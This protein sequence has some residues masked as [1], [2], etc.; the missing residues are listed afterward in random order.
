MTNQALIEA[1]YEHRDLVEEINAHNV[2]VTIARRRGEQARPYRSAIR[3]VSDLT[4]IEA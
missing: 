3:E 1:I 4:G 2:A